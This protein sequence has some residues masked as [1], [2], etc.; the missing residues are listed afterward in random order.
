MGLQDRNDRFP[1]RGERIASWV[2]R[3]MQAHGLTVSELA[4]RVNADKRDVRRMLAER[5]CGSRLND[6]LEAA[7]GWDF[8]EQVATP[9]VGADP[10]TFRE[11]QLEQHQAQVA[12]IHARLER[13]RAARSTPSGV[14]GGGPV[15][16]LQTGGGG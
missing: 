10:L 8:I 4:F 13:E 6:D 7:F 16:A 12:A 1:A 9:V 11:A 3:Y 2:E 14:G 5:T 15:R